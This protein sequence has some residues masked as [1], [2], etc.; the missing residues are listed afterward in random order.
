MKLRT[1]TD[2]SLPQSCGIR[3]TFC[4][5]RPIRESHVRCNCFRFINRYWL[6]IASEPA[7]FQKIID[8]LADDALK[9][10][11][12]AGCANDARADQESN[13]ILV[14]MEKSKSLSD[15]VQR[16]GRCTVSREHSLGKTTF[17]ALRRAVDPM[18]L[19]NGTC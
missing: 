6:R 3:S 17:I 12:L 5:R 14:C 16:H 4:G 19:A 8:Q 9:K 11:L 2:C 13:G 18:R 7:S 15:A 1:I 10:Q